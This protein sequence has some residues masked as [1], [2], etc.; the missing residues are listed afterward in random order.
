MRKVIDG[1]VYDT[2]TAYAICDIPCRFYKNDFG[3]HDTVLYRSPRGRYF[4]VGE[5]HAAS[6]W[7]VHYGNGNGSGPGSGIRVIS[8]ED[9]RAYAEKAECDEEDMREAGFAVE[10]G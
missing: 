3:W 5:G 4:L 8:A 6:M 9:A 7:A 10:E 2:E 1:K